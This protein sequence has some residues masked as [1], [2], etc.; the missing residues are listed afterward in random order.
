MED[1]QERKLKH[2]LRLE[3]ERHKVVLSSENKV[4]IQLEAVTTNP[5]IDLNV[6]IKIGEFE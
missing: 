1:E 3:C 6:T 5:E 4:T 2:R